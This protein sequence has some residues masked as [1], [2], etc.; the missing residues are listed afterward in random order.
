MAL[1]RPKKPVNLPDAGA[2]RST[3]NLGCKMADRDPGPVFFV[4][5]AELIRA[6]NLPEKVGRRA[7]M[8]LDHHTPGT[9]AFP[10]KDPRFGNRRFFP[11]S[12]NG[13]VTTTTLGRVRRLRRFRRPGPKRGTA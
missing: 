8:A 11:P 5:D 9:R 7:L 4:T 10:P 2:V 12:S 6:L 13:L 3:L 1:L